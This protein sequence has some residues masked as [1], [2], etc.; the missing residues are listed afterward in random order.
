M[1]SSS[2][3]RGKLFPH[4][5]PPFLYS[6][7]EEIEKVIKDLEEQKR[8]SLDAVRTLKRAALALQEDIDCK[9]NSLNIDNRW[10]AGEMRN[11][12][13]RLLMLHACSRRVLAHF[14]ILIL[15]SRAPPPFAAA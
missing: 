14:L 5:Q 3:R 9:L 1:F 6:E 11:K 10:V 7:V 4:H 8:V 2:R 15:S 12:R 13:K